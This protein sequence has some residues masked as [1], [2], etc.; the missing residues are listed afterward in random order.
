MRAWRTSSCVP[1]RQFGGAA[2]RYSGGDRRV[3]LPRL[4]LSL[5]LRINARRR[6]RLTTEVMAPSTKI[7]GTIHFPATAAP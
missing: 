2:D 5:V 4:S 3:A 1:V 7:V 6:D